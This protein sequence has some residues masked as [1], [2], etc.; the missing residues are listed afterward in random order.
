MPPAYLQLNFVNISNN[1]PLQLT[2]LEG[3]TDFYNLVCPRTGKF[4]DENV[5]INGKELSHV[6]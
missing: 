3:H 2:L 5:K 6:H 4:W 1:S